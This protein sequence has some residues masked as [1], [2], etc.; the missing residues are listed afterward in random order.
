MI[1]AIAMIAWIAS[2]MILSAGSLFLCFCL[3]CSPPLC[4]YIIAL[5]VRIVKRFCKII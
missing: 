5:Y 3:I 4:D 2:S 1:V